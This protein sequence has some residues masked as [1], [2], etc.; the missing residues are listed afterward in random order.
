MASQKETPEQLTR[1][2]ADEWG[3]C[4]ASVIESM[5]DSKPAIHCDGT[6]HPLI[7]A[8]GSLHSEQEFN[9]GPECVL[10]V[11]VPE[12]VWRDA[13]ARVLKAAGIDEVGRDDALSTFQEILSQTFSGVAQAIGARLGKEVN[14][15]TRSEKETLPE[16]IAGL[17]LAIELP[18]ADLKDYPV[19][20]SPAADLLQQLQETESPPEAAAPM[21]ATPSAAGPSSISKTFDLLLG[22]HLPV[23]VSFGKTSM[24]VKEVLK[25]TTG[26]IVELNRAVTEPVDI[27]V[28]NCIIARGDVVV[29]AGNYG[30]RVREI[31]SKE[32]RYQTG[33]RPP[34]A[35]GV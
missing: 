24:M 14:C 16:N 30:V 2:L 3:H 5:A 22:V 20:I 28:N 7:S 35:T 32:Q 34:L 1:W 8:E 4:F 25:L 27:I 11:S 10:R 13:G 19:W 9:L 33:L 21:A 18:D 26:S 12:L 31:V 17:S 6:S 15:G 23:S 29:V